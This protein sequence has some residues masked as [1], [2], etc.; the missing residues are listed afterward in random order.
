MMHSAWALASGTFVLLLVR[1]AMEE[2]T[3]AALAPLRDRP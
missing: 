1:D 2:A 3:W